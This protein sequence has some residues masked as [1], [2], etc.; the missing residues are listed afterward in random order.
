[1]LLVTD[2]HGGQTVCCAQGADQCAAAA[3]RP[4]VEDAGAELDFAA[5]RQTIPGLNTGGQGAHGMED[6]DSSGAG[7]ILSICQTFL[8]DSAAARHACDSES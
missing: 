2:P 8:P 1:M 5:A 4:A 3:D 7:R 6:L